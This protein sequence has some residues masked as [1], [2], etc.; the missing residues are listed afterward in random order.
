MANVVRDPL[1]H[2]D[3]II[4]DFS[5][6]DPALTF[7]KDDVAFVYGS[8]WK[9]RYFTRKGDDYF[10]LPAQ[11]DI[12]HSRWLPYHVPKNADW[13][14]PLYPDD[15]MQ[16]PTGPLCDGC[17]SVNYDIKAKSV[18][19]W[20]VGCESCHGAGS[21]HL[22]DPVRTTIINP[23]RLDYV[24]ANDTCIR[25]HSQ[26]RPKA[27]PIDGKYYDWPVGFH[28][29]EQGGGIDLHPFPG[30]NGAQESDAGQ[31][32]RSEPHVHARRDLLLMSRS[33]R[34]RQRFDATREG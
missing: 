31:R 14:A 25:C 1:E 9:Q 2:P 34:Q 28:M 19:E 8:R 4:P 15:N 16:R 22:A 5:K 30:R 6:P 24:A 32:L 11:W 13:W 23:T 29:G 3:A 26:G 20:N 7:T 27:N 10:P 17:H 12:T 18:T 33:S 21:A